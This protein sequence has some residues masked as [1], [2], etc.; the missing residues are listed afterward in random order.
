MSMPAVAACSSLSRGASREIGPPDMADDDLGLGQCRDH[1]L[2]VVEVGEDDRVVELFAHLAED[3][4]RD[5]RGEAAEE[6]GFHGEPGPQIVVTRLISAV[7]AR[8]AADVF[9]DLVPAPPH[10]AAGPAGIVRRHDDVRQLVERVARAAAVR[11]GVGRVLPPDIDR[12]AAEPA[13]AQR[14]IQRVLVDHRAARDVDQERIGFISASRRASIS[15]VVSGPSAVHSATVSHS[16][17]IRSSSAS[18]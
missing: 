18:G 10:H 17:S 5:A 2:H 12:R 15:P 16:G 1:P 14:G 11:L 9:G 4:R 7:A 3:A 6:Q 13:V 8:E